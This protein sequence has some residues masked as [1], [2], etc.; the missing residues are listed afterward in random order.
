MKVATQGDKP[1]WIV[2]PAGI[3]TASV[4]RMSGKL[5]TENCQDVEVVNK[6]GELEHRSMVYT[7]YFVR[8]TE[9]ATYC[10]LHEPRGVMPKIA[11]FLG[12]QQQPAPMRASDQSAPAV[13]TATTGTTTGPTLERVDA[14]PQ[15]PGTKRGFWSRILGRGRNDDAQKPNDPSIPKKKSGG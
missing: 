7:D 1:D 14:P 6:D 8:G 11:D 2:Q 9:P 15:P 4:C 13:P 5:A 10:D 12:G 3:T